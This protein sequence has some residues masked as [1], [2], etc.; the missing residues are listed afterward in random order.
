MVLCLGEPPGGFCDVSCCCCFSPLEVFTFPCYFSLPL[1]LHPGFWGPWRPP[2]A[3]SSTLTNF[4]CFTFCQAFFITFLLRALRFWVGIFYPQAFFFTLHSF[5]IFLAR[6]CDSDAGTNTPSRIFLCACPHRV[7]PSG[8]RMDLNNS[9]CSYK[10][11]DL[12]IAPVSYE[13]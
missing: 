13:V 11:I 9:H 10:T 2:L 1:A 8:W 4:S 3:L 6:F 12:S 7:V 5:P